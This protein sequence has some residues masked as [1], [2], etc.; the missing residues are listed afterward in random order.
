MT[1]EDFNKFCGSLAATSYID[2]ETYMMLPENFDNF[3]N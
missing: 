1:Y 2:G 3:F